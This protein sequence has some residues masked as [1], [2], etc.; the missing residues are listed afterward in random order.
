MKL[1]DFIAAMDNLAPREL[2][3]GFDNVG[4]L[5]GTER[6]DIKKVLVALDCTTDVA[7]SAS[8]RVVAP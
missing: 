5:I 6:R 7:D 3:L 4:L 8:A 1:T 2:A